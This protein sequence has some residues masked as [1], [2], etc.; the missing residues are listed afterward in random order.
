MGGNLLDFE[1]ILG[2]ASWRQEEATLGV[3]ATTLQ[4]RLF[5]VV[6]EPVI[7]LLCLYHKFLKSRLYVMFFVREYAINLQRKNPT[8]Q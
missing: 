4:G 3:P 5:L 6:I 1:T 2:A 7:L 8:L